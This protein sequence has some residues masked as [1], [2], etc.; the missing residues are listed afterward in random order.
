MLSKWYGL[1]AYVY[2][3]LFLYENQYILPLYFTYVNLCCKVHE[4]DVGDRNYGYYTE[5]IGIF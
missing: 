5:E 4:S 2:Y 3:E 1:C